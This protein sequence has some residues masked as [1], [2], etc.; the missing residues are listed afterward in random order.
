[1]FL[2]NQKVPVWPDGQT[3]TVLEHPT[4]MSTRFTDTEHYHPRLIAKIL[5]MEQRPTVR[6]N[7]F[8]GACGT[9]VHHVSQW[10][11]SEADLINAR[12][13]EF[14]RRALNEQNAVVDISWANVYRRGDYCMP[15]SHLRATASVVYFLE[16]GDVVASD[17]TGGR[18]GFFD[19]RLPCC[20]RYQESCMTT[21]Y[22][23]QLEPGTMLIF[24]AMLVHSVN[25]YQG[26][27]PRMTMSWNI[28]NVAFAGSPLPPET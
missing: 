21:P 15:H 26:T 2:G 14:Y 24:P 6:K 20:C 10:G 16:S 19:P 27:R 9:K 13:E 23:P 1:M 11:V 17:P 25:P 8:P 7:Y 18:F 28:N 3:I 22:F 5:E 4:I 12:A